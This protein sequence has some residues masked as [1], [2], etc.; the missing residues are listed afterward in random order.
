MIYCVYC[1][2]VQL[3]P[4]LMQNFNEDNVVTGGIGIGSGQLHYKLI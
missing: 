2:N 1:G 3:F 4:H